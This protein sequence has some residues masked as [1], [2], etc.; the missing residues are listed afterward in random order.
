MTPPK[1]VELDCLL[2]YMSVAS[3]NYA[4]A[5]KLSK[6]WIPSL[7]A[8]Y[9]QPRQ[10]T[11]GKLLQ[12]PSP[13]VSPELS[14]TQKFCDVIAASDVSKHMRIVYEGLFP[15]IMNNDVAGLSLLVKELGVSFKKMVH[16]SKRKSPLIVAAS[17]GKIEM[18]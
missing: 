2:E 11:R 10:W 12:L 3:M 18:V 5:S 14:S 4:A 8:L 15:C 16:K 13:S 7:K 1:G 17:K 6:D 9:L